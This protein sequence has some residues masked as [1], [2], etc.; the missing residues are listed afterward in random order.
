MSF[1]LMASLRT[2][3]EN[4]FPLLGGSSGSAIRGEGVIFELA[5]TLAGEQYQ[6]PCAPSLAAL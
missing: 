3:N 4:F 1:E 5:Q 6:N 2:S